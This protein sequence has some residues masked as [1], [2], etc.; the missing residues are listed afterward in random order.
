MLKAKFPNW[1]ED[2]WESIR[3]YGN[4][5]GGTLEEHYY[6]TGQCGGQPITKIAVYGDQYVDGVELQ[7]G[8]DDDHIYIVGTRVET[9]QQIVLNV[10]SV[11]GELVVA[12]E[13]VTS[14]QVR[15]GYL[16]DSLKFSTNMNKVLQA[17]GTG[18]DEVEPEEGCKGPHGKV[19]GRLG[20][21]MGIRALTTDHIM[22]GEN[23]LV[24]LKFVWSWSHPAHMQAD[25]SATGRQAAIVLPSTTDMASNTGSDA[26]G[27]DSEQQFEDSESY[28][29]GPS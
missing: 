26:A 15:C 19:E 14:V 28:E 27:D 4:Y 13:Y 2:V 10:G 25:M 17:G 3:E 23:R 9:P 18:G 12:R 21:L 11:E 8:D 6:T 20:R 7:F 29:D 5:R 22:M 24:M 16:I 1:R